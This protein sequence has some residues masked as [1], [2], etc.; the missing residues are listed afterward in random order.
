MPGDVCDEAIALRIIHYIAHER[1]GLAPIVVVLTQRIC[2]PDHLAIGH[3]CRL[4]TDFRLRA[5]P[6]I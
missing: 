4:A 6:A 2:C 5:G 3:P 1:A